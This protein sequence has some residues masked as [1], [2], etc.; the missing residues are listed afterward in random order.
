MMTG[1]PLSIIK[2]FSFHW[3]D[4]DDTETKGVESICSFGS[5][6]I[7]ANWQTFVASHLN[8]SMSPSTVGQKKRTKCPV[9]P[10]LSFFTDNKLYLTVLS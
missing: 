5:H 4:I 6:Y 2:T 3:C 7:Y 1:H 10:K 9:G 8:M